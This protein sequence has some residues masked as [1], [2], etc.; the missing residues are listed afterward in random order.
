MSNQ[1]TVLTRDAAITKLVNSQ[2]EVFSQEHDWIREVLQT[3]HVGLGSLSDKAVE[4]A[5]NKFFDDPIEV[6]SVQIT[7]DKQVYAAFFMEGMRDID[8][9]KALEV[10]DRGCTELVH[11]VCSYIDFMA[12]AVDARIKSYSHDI[13]FPG[14]FE[15]EVCSPFGAFMIRHLLAEKDLPARKDAEAWLMKAVDEFWSQ[16]DQKL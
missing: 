12:D 9:D 13:S 10:W 1:P 16:G 2:V 15:Y 14:V 6:K 8:Y 3:G 5:Y 11:E 4:N 7:Q